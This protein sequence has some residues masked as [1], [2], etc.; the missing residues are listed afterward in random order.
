MILLDTHIWVWWVMG[1]ERLSAKQKKAINSFENDGLCLSIISLWEVAKLEELGKIILPFKINKWLEEAISYPGI[2]IIDLSL[3][4]ILKSTNLEGN[5]HKD[6]MNQIIVAT[7]ITKNIPL[8]TSDNQ[9]KK[10][11]FV[12]TI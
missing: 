5:L 4:I 2:K 1:D 10:Y 6:P 3:D 9:I 12:K 7:A 8:V 11:K